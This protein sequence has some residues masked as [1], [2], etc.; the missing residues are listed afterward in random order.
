MEIGSDRSFPPN[1][2]LEPAFDGTIETMGKQC[3]CKR[4]LEGTERNISKGG[5]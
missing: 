1:L 3:P 2:I 5:R 4:K